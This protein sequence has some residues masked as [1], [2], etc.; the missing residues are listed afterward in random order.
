[1]V[2]E[3]KLQEGDLLHA[4]LHAAVGGTG[5]LLSSGNA[6][7]A[8]SGAAGGA[9]SSLLA[10]AFETIEPLKPGA[11]NEGRE[12]RRNLI[13]SIIAGG[14]A[15]SG[16]SGA[17]ATAA[18][19][20]ATAAVDNNFVGL[21][22]AAAVLGT[23]TLVTTAYVATKEML[24]DKGKVE[25]ISNLLEK[26]TETAGSVVNN[27]KKEFT[28]SES[29]AEST[30]ESKDR[31]KSEIAGNTNSGNAIPPDDDEYEPNKKGGGKN[32]KHANQHRKDMAREKFEK[33]KA[34]YE[35][36]NAKPRKTS[37]DVKLKDKAEKLMKHLRKKAEFTGEHHS[38]TPKGRR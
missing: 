14:A 25:S 20:A 38:Q 2:K 21:D 6:G 32:S 28:K 1:L 34:E 9:A 35:R 26:V 7:S 11:T 31:T 19:T 16:V 23:A 17:D 37:E 15:A 18:T 3:G 30:T 22:D 10:K 13:T 29:K 27:I 36:L 33:A 8:L 24:N 12:A 5:A 4:T